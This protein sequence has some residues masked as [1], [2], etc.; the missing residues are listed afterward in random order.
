[1]L[2]NRPKTKILVDGGDPNETLRIK[3]L[4]G[5]VDGQTTSPPLIAKNP[6]IQRLV[7]SGH[8]LSSDEEK[9]EYRRIVQSISPLVGDAGVSIEVFADLNTTGEDMFS[10]GQEMFSW[11]PNAYVKYPC[12]HEGLRAAQMSVQKG[13]RVNMTLCFSQEQAAAVYAATKG[14]KEPVYVSPFVGRLDDRG[15]DGMDLVRSIQKMYARSDGHVHVLAAS[16]RSV[17]HLLCSFALGAELATVPTT[18]L[19]EWAA[20]GFPMPDQDFRYQGVDASGKPLKE[21]PYK[22]LGLELPWQRFDIAHELTT[23]GIQ[24]FVADYQSTLRRSA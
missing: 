12:T 16:I 6:K 14:S 17:N 11:I 7:A 4:I 24:K 22:G 21:I 5:F 8:S 1:M 19:D 10:Q 15:E 3:N 2:T 20:K 9:A 18:V 23:K 13:I